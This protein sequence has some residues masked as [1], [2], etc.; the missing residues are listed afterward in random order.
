VT[1]AREMAGAILASLGEE[2]LRATLRNQGLAQATRFSWRKTAQS[3]LS[4][5]EG[6]LA[7]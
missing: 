4:V 7:E 1:S 5:F 3:T 2:P 6:V